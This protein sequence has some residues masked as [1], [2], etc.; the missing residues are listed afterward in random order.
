M[1]L[2]EGEHG[3]VVGFAGLFVNDLF[4]TNLAVGVDE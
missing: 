1:R 4:V 2:Q 3:I